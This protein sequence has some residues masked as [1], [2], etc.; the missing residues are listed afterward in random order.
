MRKN[1][2]KQKTKEIVFS[3]K[4]IEA[5][6]VSLVGEFNNWNPDPDRVSPT[7]E[8]EPP[9]PTTLTNGSPHTHGDEPN[10]FHF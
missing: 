4:A 8:E 7:Q 9:D 10:P 6:K 3:L 5:K 2:L 1:K